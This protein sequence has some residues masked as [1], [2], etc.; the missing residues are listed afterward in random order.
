MTPGVEFSA[1]FEQ[2]T[3]PPPSHSL[4]PALP[5]ICRLRQIPRTSP[6]TAISLCY[7]KRYSST[8]Y[9]CGTGT[10]SPSTASGCTSC[11]TG[12]Y[13]A[14]TAKSSCTS[15]PGG[16]Y[17]DVAAQT[18]CKG[19]PGVSD[20]L[21]WDPRCLIYCVCY[22]F[23]I[24]LHCLWCWALNQGYYCPAGSAGGVACPGG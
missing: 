16:Q 10:Y 14:A 9:S 20:L 22:Y 7:L 4:F 8:Y 24:G 5:C 2:L 12:Q 13:N 19:C 23:L 18:S 1:F 21:I 6:L 15:C 17:Q 3:P 11:P